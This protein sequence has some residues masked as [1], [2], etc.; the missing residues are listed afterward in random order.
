MA[1]QQHTTDWSSE[2][3]SV[4]LCLGSTECH[5]DAQRIELFSSWGPRRKCH[6]V[7]HLGIFFTL[8]LQNAAYYNCS[9]CFYYL[10]IIKFNKKDEYIR[11]KLEPWFHGGGVPATLSLARSLT[12]LVFQ[13]FNTFGINCSF[14]TN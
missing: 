6:Y 8:G 12:V 7:Q 9:I 4:I 14:T 13:G 11:K 10:A 2:C 3:V 5:H 1:F